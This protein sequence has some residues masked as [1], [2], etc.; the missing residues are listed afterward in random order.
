MTVK[1]VHLSWKNLLHERAGKRLGSAVFDRQVA[2]SN[3][4]PVFGF[5]RIAEGSLAS[6]TEFIQFRIEI[7]RRR[8]KDG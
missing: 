3:K 8:T 4:S 2:E 1:V 6:L 7:P 5:S